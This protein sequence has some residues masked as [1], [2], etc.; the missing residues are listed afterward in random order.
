M[1]TLLI[2]LMVLLLSCDESTEEKAKANTVFSIEG[3]WEL[4]EESTYS[5]LLNKVVTRQAL[6][7]EK[8]ILTFKSPDSV[9]ATN[10]DCAGTYQINER[11]DLGEEMVLVVDMQFLC[12][13][14]LNLLYI[15]S[16][17]DQGELGLSDIGENAPDEGST[18][19]FRKV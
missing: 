9:V 14:E 7:A 1:K 6:E 16:M 12:E 15:A 17:N 8:Y 11:S 18:L 4:K 5:I 2:S 13:D 10:R 3:S 19:I